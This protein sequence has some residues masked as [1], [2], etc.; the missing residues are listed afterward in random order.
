MDDMLCL[1]LL[2]EDDFEFIYKLYCEKSQVY[3]SGHSEEPEKES[4]LRWFNNILSNPNI[5]PYIILDSNGRVGFCRLVISDDNKYICNASAISISEKFRGRGY[6]TKA[7]SLLINEARL[8]FDIQYMYGWI[9]D[10]HEVSKRMCIRNGFR[11][12]GKVREQFIPLEGRN[13]CMYE[14]VLDM[15][16]EP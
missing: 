7:I 1:R 15:T 6:G 9:L 13:I 12:T 2:R 14:Y 8:K 16:K 5:I 3:W 11:R 4:L 10:T